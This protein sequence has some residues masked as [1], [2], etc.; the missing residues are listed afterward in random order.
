[1]REIRGAIKQF[2]DSAPQEDERRLKLDQMQA[3]VEK[4]RL[5]IEKLKNSDGDTEDDL[6]EAWVKAVE[7]G[8]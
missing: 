6:I 5:E 3:T 4:T 7:S 8:E 2:L 1:M